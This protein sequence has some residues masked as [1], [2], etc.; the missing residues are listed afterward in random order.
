MLVFMVVYLVGSILSGDF[1]KVPLTVAFLTASAY[2]VCITP[3][4][5]LKDPYAKK[6]L[7]TWKKWLISLAALVVVAGAL[8]LGNLLAWAKLPSPLPRFH[9]TEM[10]EAVETVEAAPETVEVTDSIQ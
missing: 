10:V 7:P 4:L 8:W 3:K 2:A 9:K 5:K 1:Y 6:G